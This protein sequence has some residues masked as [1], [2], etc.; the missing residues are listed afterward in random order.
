MINELNRKIDGNVMINAH[1]TYYS[2][3]PLEIFQARYSER[4]RVFDSYP[5]TY[6]KYH[7]FN[8]S[9]YAFLMR[10]FAFKSYEGF[11]IARIVLIA[12]LCAVLVEL[13]SDKKRSHVKFYFSIVAFCAFIFTVLP[14]QIYW[15]L[16]MNHYINIFLIIIFFVTIHKQKETA[17]S[18]AFL[19]PLFISSG[20]TA[21][22]AILMGLFMLFYKFTKQDYLNIIKH[23][24]LKL[25]YF[26]IYVAAAISMFIAGNADGTINIK[27]VILFLLI[28]FSSCHS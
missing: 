4:L 14:N 6:P 13:I 23:S 22:P 5:I 18:L 21:F 9:I 8:G 10:I 7:F 3:V 27:T 20:R 1:Q 26:F 15:A 11:M 17:L 25:T 28:R 24:Y 16:N 2:G 19:A 12:L